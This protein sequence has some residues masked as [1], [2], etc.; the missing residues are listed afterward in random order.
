MIFLSSIVLSLCVVSLFAQDGNLVNISEVYAEEIQVAG[1]T[2]SSEQNISIEA[3]TIAPRRNYRDFHFSYAWI[4]NS[5]SR[6][7]VW[8]LSD[9]EMEDRNRY[10]ATHEDEIELE[11]GTYEVYYSTYPHFNFDDDFYYHWGAR[12][13]F[14]GIFNAIFDDD[15]DKYGYFEDLYDEL[16][17]NVNG[18]GTAL[19]ADDIKERQEALMDEAFIAFTSLRDDEFEEQVFKITS[20]VELNVYAL[21][22]A[23]RDGDYDFGAIINLKTR[24]R[25]WSLTYRHSDNAGGARKNRVAREVIKLEPGVYKALYVT[26]DSHS[27]R[28]WNTGPPFDPSFWGMTIW[29]ESSGGES[30]LV[31]L[32]SDEDPNAVPVV[33]FTK[34]RDEEY[35]SQGFTLKKPLN[36]DFYSV[37]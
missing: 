20:P 7:L 24:E 5:D 37:G 31:K 3:V 1:F 6:E 27:Y 25:V 16:Y 29:I 13:F 30:S 32:D 36:L 26:D 23:R 33:E 35:L 34:V 9:A 10:K 12:G 21:G 18:T 14:S 28:R 8:E 2:L 17:F 11:A 4:L 19:S 22:E 15:D